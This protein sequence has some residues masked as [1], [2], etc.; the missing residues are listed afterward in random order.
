MNVSATIKKSRVAKAGS[1]KRLGAV[2][3]E[4]VRLEP[5]R[6]VGNRG[7]IHSIFKRNEQQTRP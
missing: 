5:N 3:E 1:G 2:R 7:Q 4:Q 6:A